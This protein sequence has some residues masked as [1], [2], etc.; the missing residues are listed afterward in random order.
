MLETTADLEVFWA[1]NEHGEGLSAGEREGRMSDRLK[2]PLQKMMERVSKRRPKRIGM[3]I[4]KTHNARDA[5]SL[6]GRQDAVEIQPQCIL[7]T[8][9]IKARP[10]LRR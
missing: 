5:N 3:S 9:V 2:A 1:R 8:Q 7:W 10:S 4:G 6:A